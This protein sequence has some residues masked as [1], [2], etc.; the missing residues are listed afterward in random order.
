MRRVCF[1]A[2][3]CLTMLASL[4]YGQ[5]WNPTPMVIDVPA[6]VQYKF[7]GS[8]IDIPFSL[9]GKPAMIWLVVNTQLTDTQKP[10]AVTNGFKG[11]HFVN[12]IDTTVYVSTGRTFSVG[13]SL[14]FPWDGHGS[15][16]AM[17]TTVDSGIVPPGT[18]SYYM[19][20]YD[21]VSSREVANN[22]IQI[23]HHSQ[24]MKN[25][26]YPYDDKTGA[27]LDRPL[28]MGTQN[29]SAADR[30]ND[31]AGIAYKF[32]LGDDPY[33]QSKIETTFMSGF[34]KGDIVPD[35]T[36][37]R[38]NLI[39]Q[40]NDYN[41]MYTC[42]AKGWELIATI[43]KWTYVPRGEAIQDQGWGDWGKVTFQ[44]YTT[45]DLPAGILNNDANYMYYAVGAKNPV[46]YQTDYLAAFPW[47]DPADVQ[48][49]VLMDEF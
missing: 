29:S 7:D 31:R 23:G 45:S 14:T 9:S 5:G 39:F 8:N 2:F 42:L 21:N 11:W 26:F 15:E 35:K 36:I 17:D 12:G 22:F 4:A 46:L 19:I 20:G 25:R 24:V 44:T 43:Q 16:K 32:T 37:S 38:G 41:T 27:L 48:F 30:F 10:V 47:D 40:P 13:T 49:N 1:F 34:A 18:Y 3:T 33:D 28:L 6:S